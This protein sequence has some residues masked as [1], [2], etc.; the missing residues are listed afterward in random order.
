MWWVL[1]CAIN[2]IVA[3]IRASDKI[4]T[5]SNWSALRHSYSPILKQQKITGQTRQSYTCFCR[6]GGS[7]PP[8]MWVTTALVD[9]AFQ[10]LCSLSVSSCAAIAAWI[11]ENRTFWTVTW[12]FLSEFPPVRPR[13][14]R[15]CRASVQT[16]FLLSFRLMPEFIK[17]DEE[18]YIKAFI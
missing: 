15:A 4:F 10:Q 7:R 3:E 18:D 2:H 13:D 17:V 1:L 16:L 5:R 11:M 8:L 9:V 12:A 14:R 6:Q